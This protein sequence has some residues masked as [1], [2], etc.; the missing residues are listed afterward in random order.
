MS[1]AYHLVNY[2]KFNLGLP[3]GPKLDALCR[4]ALDE[5]DG[6]GLSR[7]ERIQSRFH[8][9]NDVEKREITLNRV[10][11]LKSAVFGEMCLV[12]ANGVQALLELNASKKQLS[13]IT[14]AEVFDL[15]EKNAPKGTQFIRG[16]AYWLAVNDNL[17]FVK[18]QSLSAEMVHNY[19][20]WLVSAHTPA[21]SAPK[22]Q[23]EFDRTQVA[24][25]IGDINFIKVSGKG[26]PQMAILPP[27]SKEHKKSVATSRKIAERSFLSD[28]AEPLTE[29]IFGKARTESLV[30]SLGPEEYLAVDASVRVRGRRTEASKEKMTQIA[31]DLAE[32]TD[33]KV[34]VEGKDGRLTQDDAILR[35]RMP[36]LLPHEGS[37][38]LDFDNVADQLQ[39]VYSRFVRDGKIDA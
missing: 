15:S 11:D 25:D 33:T 12:Q 16:M 22:F 7:W 19:I 18:T 29:V 35:T 24:G 5:K 32:L 26:M 30:E 3:G 13:D 17:F 23:A 2:R 10:A 38:L 31:N 9:L 28:K 1:T 8:A 20:A 4:G 14:T 6:S 36:F 37:N 39:E 27:D 21:G 34:Q